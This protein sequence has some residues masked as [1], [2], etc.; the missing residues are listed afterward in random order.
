[1]L[2][3]LRVAALVTKDGRGLKRASTVS[4]HLMLLA[5]VYVADDTSYAKPHDK[6]LPQAR[7]S[8]ISDNQLL[9]PSRGAA[10][11]RGEKS[12]VGLLQPFLSDLNKRRKIF[13]PQRWQ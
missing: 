13:L 3:L 4:G 6:H 2:G 10:L 7:A 12:S 8:D 11:G 1:M 9:I 5:R